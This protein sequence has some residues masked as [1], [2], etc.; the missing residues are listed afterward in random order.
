[1]KYCTKR[2]F[3]PALIAC[4]GFIQPCEAADDTW[5]VGAAGGISFLE[6]PELHH[7]D[8]TLFTPFGPFPGYPQ[9]L[10][11]IRRQAVPEFD[12]GYA[13]SLVAGRRVSRWFRAELELALDQQEL[14]TVRTVTGSS[15]VV[16][17][18]TFE[19]ADIVRQ[20]NGVTHAASGQLSSY[21]FF[22]NGWFDVPLDSEIKPYIGGG[23]GV[24]LVDADLS[25]G[26]TAPPPIPVVANGYDFTDWGLALQIGGGLRMSITD[27]LTID[28]GYRYRTISGIDFSPRV[29]RLRQINADVTSHNVL[30]GISFA[31]AK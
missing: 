17:E 28:L 31:L 14:D 5:Y 20:G 3:A 15:I 22:V 9:Q 10:F 16:F 19:P 6:Q 24:S 25:W 4:V 1:M 18:G 27:R 8:Q 29:A 13:V 12:V 21:S 7:M 2:V 26:S 11:P 30:A 23:A